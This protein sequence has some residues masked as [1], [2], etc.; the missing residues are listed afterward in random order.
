M[1]W[2]IALAAYLLI[3]GGLSASLAPTGHSRMD[4]VGDFDL[5]SGFLLICAAMVLW[6]VLLALAANGRRS[7]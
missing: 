4:R 1:I 7:R 5:V 3:G 2:P 6:P